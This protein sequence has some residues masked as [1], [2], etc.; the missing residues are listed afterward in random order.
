MQDAELKRLSATLVEAEAAIKNLRKS[1]KK[2][3][4]DAMD[5]FELG[6]MYLERTK[7]PL[8][9]K[10][11]APGLIGTPLWD[12]LRGETK[13]ET[14]N[15]IRKFLKD[16]GVNKRRYSEGFRYYVKV[17]DYKVSNENK[18]AIIYKFIQSKIS[19]SYEFM[20]NEEILKQLYKSEVGEF[21][22][23]SRQLGQYL[24]QWLVDNKPIKKD[25]IRGKYGYFIKINL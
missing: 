6:D 9:I 4:P 17:K 21:I 2:L 20:T 10:E 22:S 19:H 13:Q 23:N 11:F 14:D 7:V 16:Y 1:I 5:R 24:S 15:N 12:L 18:R 3:D 25:R 8:T